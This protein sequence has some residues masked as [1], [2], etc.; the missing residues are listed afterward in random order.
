MRTLQASKP[1][2]FRLVER[3]FA[4]QRQEIRDGSVFTPGW[5]CTMT[6]ARLAADT[7]GD[8][9]VLH[10]VGP[11]TLSEVQHL[12]DEVRAGRLTGPVT[13]DLAGASALDTAGAWLVTDML[14]R[15]G[16]EFSNATPSQ[17]G[18]LDTVAQAMP[19]ATGRTTRPRIAHGLERLGQAVYAGLAGLAGLLSF[20]GQIVAVAL[21]TCLH[22]GRLRLT[23]LVAHIA[24]A[25]LGAAPIVALMSFLIGIVLAYQGAQQLTQ[26]GAEV[27]VVELVAVSLLRELGSAVDGHTCRRAFGLGLHG[28][29]R[30]DENARGDRRDAHHRA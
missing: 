14:R 1:E 21:Y 15:L 8:R 5:P 16:G 11:I 4:M 17:Q 25:G 10:F 6:A 26:F 2:P 23:A 12:S 7:T 19:Q 28:R 29:H 20:F 30:L 22:P 3:L 27:F 9:P 18:L 24:Q 13:I